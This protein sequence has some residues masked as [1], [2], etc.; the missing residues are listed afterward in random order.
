MHRRTLPGLLILS[1]LLLLPLPASATFH[2][3]KIVEVF[4]GATVEPSA[5]YVV[6]QMYFPGQNLVKT[7]SL[8]VFDATGTKVG[9]F[10]FGGN[11]SNGANLATMLVATPTAEDLFGINADLM[12][13]PVLQAGGGAA[14]WDVV[15]CVAWGSFDAANL[16]PKAPGT[17]F[18]APTGLLLDMAMHRDLS[19]GGAA[20]SFAFAPPAPK[21]NA[22]QSGTLGPTPTPSATPTPVVTPTPG[23]AGDCSGDSLVTVDEILTLVNIALGSLPISACMPGDLNHDNEI[24]VNEILTAVNSALNGCVTG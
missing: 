13:T 20:T 4:P 11:V 6:L 15:D 18:N 24:T 14:C 2:L 3:V 21:N 16:L 9:T 1:A 12:M 10:T 22:G 19:S 5:Q 7:H 8:T 23:C 17:P